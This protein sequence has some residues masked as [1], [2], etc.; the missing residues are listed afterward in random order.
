MLLVFFFCCNWAILQDLV[1]FAFRIFLFLCSP[2]HFFFF[3]P[4]LIMHHLYIVKFFCFPVKYSGDWTNPTC[5]SKE[6]VSL[7]TYGMLTDGFVCLFVCFP[8]VPLKI[9]LNSRNTIWH[10]LKDFSLLW[11]PR[12]F[13]FACLITL[14]F[15]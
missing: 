3:L 8:R 4:I 6:T 7:E 5:L 2:H 1:M 10:F 12:Y 11:S 13:L 14:V 9:S 15:L